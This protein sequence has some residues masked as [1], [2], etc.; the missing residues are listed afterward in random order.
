MTATTRNAPHFSV[1]SAAST[2]RAI[3]IAALC[4]FIVTAFLVD[5]QRGASGPAT[6]DSSELRT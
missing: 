3:F 6:S 4:A 2:G 1:H 5:L